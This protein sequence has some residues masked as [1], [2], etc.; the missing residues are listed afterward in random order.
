MAISGG[1]W[2]HCNSLT[3]SKPLYMRDLKPCNAKIS[4]W[5]KSLAEEFHILWV[6]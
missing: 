3:P 2:S 4:P 6:T 1:K 5:L